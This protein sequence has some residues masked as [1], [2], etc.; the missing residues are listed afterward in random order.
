MMRFKMEAA[1][2]RCD[3]YR[4]FE[5]M[6]KENV[7]DMAMD[8]IGRTAPHS[9]EVLEIHNDSTGE[10]LASITHLPRQKTFVIVHPGGSV[11]WRGYQG[12]NDR[13]M[14][15][16]LSALRVADCDATGLAACRAGSEA[17]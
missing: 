2:G 14:F 7:L 3:L 8:E 1:S 9:I 15:D 11:S 12:V 6:R 5:S 13:E 4:F 10:F 16:D 17:D